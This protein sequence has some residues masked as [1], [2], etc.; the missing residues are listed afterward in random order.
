M[1]KN[2]NS[3]IVRGRLQGI[4]GNTKV[5]IENSDMEHLKKTKVTS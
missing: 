3:S 5:T 4:L 1:M 2:S